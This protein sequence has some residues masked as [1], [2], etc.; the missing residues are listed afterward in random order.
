MGMQIRQT[1]IRGPGRALGLRFVVDAVNAPDLAS[2][3]PTLTKAHGDP[4]LG[5]LDASPEPVAAAARALREIFAI[6]DPRQAAASLNHMLAERSA[7]PELAELAD[8]RWAL[9]PHLADAST[10]ADT[11]ARVGAFALATWLAERGRCAWGLCEAPDC[12]R[13]FIDEGRRAPQRFCSS[14]CA[15]R[16]RVALHRKAAVRGA[17][18]A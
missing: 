15:T 14:T 7:Q 11:L 16:T 18:T 5:E 2:A 1:D 12:D 3:W 8:G 9:R 6:H 4:H 17:P 10:A 13:A